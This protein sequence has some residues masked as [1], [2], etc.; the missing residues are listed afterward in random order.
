M[1][2]GQF[3]GE[4]I[5]AILAIAFLGMM[6]LVYSGFTS[7]SAT[8]E[9]E[10]KSCKSRISALTRD[11][12]EGPGEGYDQLTNFL[13]TNVL[14][15]GAR[16]KTRD[17]I[18][19]PYDFSSCPEE[20]IGITT[21]VIQSA[22][23]CVIYEIL[24]LSRRCWEMNG[25]GTL[26]GY[27]WACFNAVI[28]E[29]KER[30]AKDKIN[31]RVNEIFQCSGENTLSNCRS[32]RDSSKADANVITVYAA[33]LENMK[34]NVKGKLQPCISN[35]ATYN[36]EPLMY[37][38]EDGELIL[39]ETI[40]A[41]WYNELELDYAENG[42]LRVL[43][44]YLE[45]QC[46]D[47]KL[48][49]ELNIIFTNITDARSE[50]DVYINNV[51][52]NYCDSRIDRTDCDSEDFTIGVGNKL[53]NGLSSYITLEE[54]ERVMD[55]AKVPNEGI[56]YKHY[57]GDNFALRNNEPIKESNIF[58]VTYCDG[59]LDI[60]G[61]IVPSYA[62]IAPGT[63]P[64]KILLSNELDAGGARLAGEN[65]EASCP[66]VETVDG[67]LDNSV[68]QAIKEICQTTSI[69]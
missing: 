23:N 28:G 58:Q 34:Q 63:E 43:D 11:A 5:A 62:C 38:T 49:Q 36:G 57:F 26:D 44:N 69:I 12:V 33:F 31:A 4:I 29:Y 56:S 55:V 37:E 18:I 64:K 14:E 20:V 47:S 45:N 66:I 48:K 13:N 21:N 32:K 60:W 2:K 46:Y 9:V 50:Q 1:K 8:A 54:L 10:D 3:S 35:E 41:L 51:V 52:E 65:I 16:C 53:G 68:T 22:E 19:E 25:V 30:G 39:D 7:T 17:V 61:G 67:I 42:K 6:V 24:E 59:L 40:Y 27:N 15:F